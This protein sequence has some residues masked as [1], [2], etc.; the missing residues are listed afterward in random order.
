MQCEW[1]EQRKTETKRRNYFGCYTI[2][3]LSE[4]WWFATVHTNLATIGGR[5]AT[6]HDPGTPELGTCWSPR[7]RELKAQKHAQIE[8]KFEI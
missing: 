1:T 7:D 6:P 4:D 8:D 5:P 2:R 3:K